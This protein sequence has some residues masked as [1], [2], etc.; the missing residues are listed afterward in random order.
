MENGLK[1]LNNHVIYGQMKGVKMM[2]Y[3]LI[4]NLVFSSLTWIMLVGYILNED[5][6]KEEES[7]GDEE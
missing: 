5:E 4:A 6:K 3:L 2:I 1:C 7:E